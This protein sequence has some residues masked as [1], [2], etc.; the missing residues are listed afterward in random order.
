[1]AI[2]SPLRRAARGA[3]DTY[4]AAR[5]QAWVARLRLQLRR[6]GG[7]LVL[8]VKDA[9]LME[10]LPTIRATMTGDGDATLTLRI[11]EGVKFGR[12][13]TI[14]I[15]ALGTNLL[16]LGDRVLVEDDVKLHLNDGTIRVGATSQLRDNVRLKSQGQLLL[17]ER[18]VLGYL[19]MLHCSERIEFEDWVGLSER[20]TVVDSDHG[21][22]GSD[23]Y[24]F[25][26]PLRTAPVHFERNAFAAAGTI[27]MRGVHVGRNAVI[28]G[29]AVV[30]RGD[31]PGGWLIMGMPAKPYKP[32]AKAAPSGEPVEREDRAPLR[33]VR[34]DDGHPAGADS[35]QG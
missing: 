10:E 7:R 30:P 14:E 19:T 8:D 4:R 18:V 23:D 9:P 32:L 5:F 31:Y 17:G 35:A 33:A 25:D 1:M 27:I 12:R 34:P 3:R 6:N 15:W 22:D 21:F 13:C 2:V 16:E 11:G 28:A 29:G 20:V 24:F 26:A